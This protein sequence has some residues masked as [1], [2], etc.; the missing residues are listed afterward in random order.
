MVRALVA[1]AMF[2]VVCNPVL[3]QQGDVVTDAPLSD[4]AHWIIALVGTL[5]AARWALEAFNRPAV[6]IA[7]VPTFPRYMTSRFQYQLGSAIFVIFACGFFLLLVRLHR[8]VVETLDALSVPIP[9]EIL[10]AIKQ[11]SPS[12]LVVIIAMGAVYLYFLNKETEWNL[13]LMMRDVI[14]RWISIPQLAARIVAQIQFSLRVPE[15][16]VASVIADSKG[17]GQQDFRK[18]SNTPER[19]WAETCYMRWWLIQGH[20]TGEDAIFFSTESFAF[21]KLLDEFQRVSSDM[22]KWKSGGAVV[23][24]AIAELPQKIKDLHKRISRLVACYLIYRHDSRKELCGAARNFGIDLSVPAP[25]NP[26]RYWIVYAAVL[27]ALVYIGVC[28]SAIGYDL[29]TGQGMNFA[30]DQNRTLAWIM[31]TL[32]NYGLAIFVILLLRFTARSLQIDSNQSHLITY[33][34]T[35]L[36][37]IVAGPLGLTLAVHFFGEGRFPEM[38]LAQLY[39]NMLNW[40]LGPALVSVYISYYLDRQIYDDL[41]DIDHSSATFVWHLS[42]CFLFAAVNV[43][44][45]LPQILSLTAQ[46]NAIW[47]SPKLR[48][49]AAGCTF[50]VALGLALAA[51]FAL[52]K[53]AQAA[54]PVL[55][56]M[57]FPKL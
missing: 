28:A 21:V 13:L 19:I 32:S 39:F 33:C 51:Q 36:V 8:E 4:V 5:L 55:T 50:Y 22:E 27:V 14:Q 30:Q 42:N 9:K 3:A 23:D 41:P 48:F 54:A 2:F 18:G 10:H 52:K 7:D 12:Y 37:A 29:L 47:D 24:L 49:V 31:Y 40:G 26:L 11:Q 15:E 46:Q 35:F 38:P 6:A 25:E 44:L 56:T 57:R 1:C 20:E 53:G 17:V 34:W 43:F 45:L 16:A